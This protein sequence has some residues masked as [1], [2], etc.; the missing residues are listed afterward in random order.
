MVTG[1]LPVLDRKLWRDFLAMRG[2]A[3]AIGLVIASGVAIQLVMGG[4]LGSLDETRAAYYER[5]RFA[6]IWA[7]V[8]RAPN[9]LVE[10][11]RE[12]EGVAAAETRIAAPVLFDMP[13]M[14]EPPTGTIFSLPRGRAP[15]VSDIY[16]VRGER[17][18]PSRR[19]EA[20]VLESFALAHGLDLGDQVSV[21]IRGKREALTVSG[22][23]L[24]PEFVYAIAPG[25]LVPDPRLFGVLWMDRGALETAADAEGA[26][27]QA[28]LRL[29]RRADPTPVREALD[30]LLEPYGAA[31]AY[32]RRD[33]ISDAFVQSELD[34][35]ATMGEVLPPVFLAVAAFLVNIVISRLIAVERAQIGLMKAFGYSSLQVSIHYLKLVGL[36]AALG[37]GLGLVSGTLL[38][39][40][41][42][43][44]YTEFY[45]FPFLIFSASTG[46]F[47]IGAAVTGLAVGGGAVFA[48][49]RAARL[50][51]AVAMRAPPPPDYSR[52]AGAAMTRLGAL[53]QQTRM[54]LRQIFRW[55]LRAGL[56]VLGIAAAA[57]TLITSLY[58]TD[59]MEVMIEQNFAVANRQDVSVYFVEARGMT[60]FYD[61]AGRDGVMEAEPFRSAA[62]RLSFE[63]REVLQPLMGV[64]ADPALSRMIGPD[65]RTIAPP[66]GGLVLSED[67]AD[68]LGV[69]TGDTLIAEITIG[70][71]ATLALPVAATPTVLIG[72]G[73]QMRLSDLNAALGDSRVVS[74]A[75]LRV[76]P[77][78]QE[79]LYLDLKAAP[80]VGAVQLHRLSRQNFQ[81]MLDRSL[82]STIY[83]FVA[84]AGLIALGVVYN[85]LRVSLAER[86]REL[87]SLRVLGFS[88]ADVSYILL[89]EAAILTLLAI[90]LGSLMGAGM[91]WS[92]SH[93]MSSD[94]FRLPFVISADTFGLT[95]LT[96]IVIAVGSGLIVRRRIDR[97]DLVSVLK[98]RE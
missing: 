38:G 22:L 86:E 65:G 3:L 34:Q 92:M 89:G 21:T 40:A 78:A 48:V 96:V 47:V 45:S 77:L 54:I 36:I 75:H 83:V 51:P 10:D 12:I 26:F 70:E 98:T 2:Q 5:T 19:N 30:R 24:S 74:G 50:Q 56:T 6:D 52:S 17:P 31:G 59:A 16:L 82:G 20:V 28:V 69:T 73:A 72:S 42:A 29:S 97:L 79:A 13:G 53:D 9:A 61:L 4:M 57:T 27:T 44:L 93:A 66:P 18:D 41:M 11:I 55:P 81:A 46:D 49:S 25:Q 39:R 43:G 14:A 63:N 64:P 58:F 76:D 15:S 84:F 95:A 60:A 37:L 94:F 1:L 35:L 7:P 32:T 67:L 80:M 71:R 85:A 33:Q 91:A 87:A 62:A 88:R 90:P 8:V 23:A 68:R